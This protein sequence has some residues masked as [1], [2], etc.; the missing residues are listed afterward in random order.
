MLF[1]RYK[2]DVFISHAVEDKLGIANDLCKRLEEAG[3]S[4]W[5]SGRGLRVG[6]SIEE[7][8]FENLPQSRY[9]V[10][11]FSQHYLSKNW[12]MKEYY[13]LQ[14]QERQKRKI[15]LPIL[16]DVT[17]NDLKAK[18]ILMADK[19]AISFT[20]GMDVI[21]E[22]LVEEIKG[23]QTAPQYLDKQRKKRIKTWT[24]VTGLVLLFISMAWLG[25]IFLQNQHAPDQ[26]LIEET[27]RERIRNQNLKI[28]NQLHSQTNNWTDPPLTL[29]EIIDVFSVHSNLKSYYRNEFMFTNG[30]REIRFKK[31]VEAALQIDLDEH[32]P[33][34]AFGLKHYRLQST[35]ANFNGSFTFTF[36]NQEPVTFRTAEYQ[37]IDNG[38]YQ[39]TVAYTNHIRAISTNLVFPEGDNPKRRQLFI[40]G[41]LPAETYTFRFE[42]DQ[43]RWIALE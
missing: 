41:L 9:A 22:K 29:Q 23:E 7:V 24:A 20:K 4:V 12:T 26:E 33:F 34:H 1:S 30:Y 38:D 17:V 32:S 39:I 31:N 15:I 28:E 11:I 27:V 14:N 8:I 3:L 16:Y 37:E 10:V 2:Y 40:H 35:P 19:F 6:D 36:I 25:F 21:V 18:D 42:Q 43:W 5:Y 13:Y